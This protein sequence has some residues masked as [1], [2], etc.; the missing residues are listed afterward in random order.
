[1][2][3]VSV[4]GKNETQKSASIICKIRMTWISL[5]SCFFFSS[6]LCSINL[7]TLG[8]ISQP[9]ATTSEALSLVL[10][11]YQSP[12]SLSFFHTHTE[13]TVLHFCLAFSPFLLQLLLPSLAHSSI[14][15]NPSILVSV[16]LSLNIYWSL[17][18]H[19]STSFSLY[20]TISPFCSLY[21]SHS[22]VQLSFIIFFWD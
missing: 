7:L 6:A 16:Y 8:F 12:P 18:L 2:Y 15:P 3:S 17:A 1:M 21:L 10:S 19:F 22:R 5:S 9:N 14:W 11:L 13:C 4:L 20:L